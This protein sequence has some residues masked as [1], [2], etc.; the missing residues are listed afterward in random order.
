MDLKLKIPPAVLTLLVG[1]AM[2]WLDQYLRFSWASFEKFQWVSFILLGIGAV[3]GLLA[4][5]EFYKSATSVDPHNIHKA[6]SLVTNGIYGISRNPMYVGL[7]LILVAYG[8][9]LGNLLVFAG[10]PLFVGYMNRYQI[11]PEEKVM[12]EKFG[13]EYQKYKSDVRRWL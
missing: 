5:V 13:R 12:Q 1:V 11:I 4:L 8:F 10:P 2:W 7:L 3:F 9:H 6:S